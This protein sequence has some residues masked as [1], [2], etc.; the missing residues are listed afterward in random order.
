VIMY[1]E[2]GVLLSPEQFIRLYARESTKG[3]DCSIRR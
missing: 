1:Q 3:D 2:M